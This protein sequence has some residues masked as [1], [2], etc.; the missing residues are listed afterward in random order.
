LTHDDTDTATVTSSWLLRALRLFRELPKT[1][2]V[3]SHP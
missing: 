2:L 1:D 3:R